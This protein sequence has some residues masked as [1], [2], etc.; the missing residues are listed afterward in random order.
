MPQESTQESLAAD[1]T[2]LRCVVDGQVFRR[3]C[4]SGRQSPVAE[5]LMGAMFVEKSG[6]LLCYVI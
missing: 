6:E 5:P 3:S 1:A 4:C 2:E